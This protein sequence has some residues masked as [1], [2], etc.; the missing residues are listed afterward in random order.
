[1]NGIRHQ[2]RELY[3]GDSDRALLF[4]NG[5]LVFDVVTVLF[6]V[7]TSLFELTTWIIV[8][9]V[10]IAT[11]LI[12][13]YLAQLSIAERRFKYVVQLNSLLDVVVIFSLLA[14]AFIENMAFLRVVRVLRLLRSYIVLRQLRERFMF[15]RVHE[16]VI[17]SALNLFVFIFFVTA[18]V[19]VL[20]VR[21]NPLINSYVD[22]LYFTVTTLSTT[23]FGDITLQGTHGRILA[24]L[25]MVIGVGLFLRLV[26]TIFRPQKIHHQCPDCGL[27]LHD[28]DAIHCKHCGRTLHISTDGE[29]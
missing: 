24:I 2:I 26:Q 7:V 1:M 22:A 9:D 3:R 12:A 20:Q 15:F 5:L 8:C 11:L 25:I 16:E 14:P 29:W 28:P 21:S 18:L 17:Q 13:D 19:Y 6:F 10:I 23:G 4:R 27:K